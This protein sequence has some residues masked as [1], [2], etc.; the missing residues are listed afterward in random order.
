MAGIFKRL[1]E[2]EVK[3]HR[4]KHEKNKSKE[5]QKKEGNM[6]RNK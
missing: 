2:K 6:G 5:I 1:E 3:K 4:K